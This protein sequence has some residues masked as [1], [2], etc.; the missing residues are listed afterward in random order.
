MRLAAWILEKF[1]G[2]SDPHGKLLTRDSWDEL[3]TNI[4]LYWITGTIGSSAHV[5]YSNSHGLPPLA[6]INV[7]AGLALFP[8]DILLP[9]EGWARENLSIQRLIQMPRGGHFTAKEEPEL[10]W[11]TFARFSGRFEVSLK[12]LQSDIYIQET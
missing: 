5:Y 11:R 1:P 9:P 4:T 12:P 2:W 7:P 10:S 3:L 6:Q 8:A